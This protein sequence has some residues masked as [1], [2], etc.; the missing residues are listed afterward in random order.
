MGGR[1]ARPWEC[2][3][4]ERRGEFA[5]RGDAELGEDAVEVRA[6]RAVRDVELLSDLAVGEAFGGEVSDLEFLRGQLVAGGEV[7]PPA[8]F[9]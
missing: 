6:D 9:P 2:G 7:A 4:G 5:A 3:N 8:R 1:L